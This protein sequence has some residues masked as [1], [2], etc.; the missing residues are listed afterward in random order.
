MQ[1]N[2]QVFSSGRASQDRGGAEGLQIPSWM[3]KRRAKL[4]PKI[5]SQG[6][7]SSKGEG[8]RTSDQEDE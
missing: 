2:Q 3:T 6:K 1:R 8:S 4:E 7:S 5:Q